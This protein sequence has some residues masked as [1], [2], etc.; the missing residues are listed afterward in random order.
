MEA[1]FFSETLVYIYKYELPRRSIID[2]SNLYYIIHT[3]CLA[4]LIFLYLII[5][6]VFGG[7]YVMISGTAQACYR[8]YSILSD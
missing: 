3:T 1:V 6:I 4:H 2:K 8:Q 7:E 5:L